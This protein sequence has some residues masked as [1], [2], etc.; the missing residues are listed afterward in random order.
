MTVSG[1]LSLLMLSDS[2]DRMGGA[3]KLNT[4]LASPAE[5]NFRVDSLFGA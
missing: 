3:V 5:L 2:S 4:N 1:D